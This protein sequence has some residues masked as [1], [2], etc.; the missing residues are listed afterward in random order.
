V[1]GNA[2]LVKIVGVASSERPCKTSFSSTSRYSSSAQCH[3]KTFLVDAPI[4][5][6]HRVQHRG[7]AQNAEIAGNAVGRVVERLV[8][9][10]GENAVEIAS[11]NGHS[12]SQQVDG[13][14]GRQWVQSRS[15]RDPGSECG[16]LSEF[17]LEIGLRQQHD[18]NEFRGLAL[19]VGDCLQRVEIGREN[20]LGFV[21]EQN[22]GSIDFILLDEER[23]KR[24][25]QVEKVPHRG[26]PERCQHQPQKCRR[27]AWR[28]VGNVCGDE[29]IRLGSPAIERELR[30]DRFPRANIAHHEEKPPLFF[31]VIG[32]LRKRLAMLAGGARLARRVPRS[33]GDKKE[34]SLRSR[35]ATSFTRW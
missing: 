33:A 30:N 25:L 9:R 27:R 32:D 28:R 20:R 21:D 19:F 17:E 26:Q 4:P 34:K 7:I 3:T 2:A 10:F 15:A 11:G 16:L 23:P 22:D 24:C 5:Q 35:F 31:G 13:F 12:M 29:S 1:N 8:N 6:G 14:V 18:L